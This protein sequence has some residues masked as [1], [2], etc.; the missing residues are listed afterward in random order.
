[1]R[2]RTLK[3]SAPLSNRVKKTA[4]EEQMRQEDREIWKDQPDPS[5]YRRTG[6]PDRPDLPLTTIVTIPNDID[7]DTKTSYNINND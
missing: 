3:A 4:P 1:M 6:I 7:I 2:R 5:K